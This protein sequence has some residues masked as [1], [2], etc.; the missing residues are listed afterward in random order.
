MGKQAEPRQTAAWVR[1]VAEN[2]NSVAQELLGRAY[3]K[4]LLG[5][6]SD[7]QQ[8]KYWY[9]RAGRRKQA[10]KRGAGSHGAPD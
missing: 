5:L 10:G 8:A 4:G 2:G 6:P 1:K 3:E 9:E 7:E